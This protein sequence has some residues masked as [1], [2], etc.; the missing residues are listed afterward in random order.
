[1]IAS[2]AEVNCPLKVLFVVLSGH[3]EEIRKKERRN[4]SGT[5]H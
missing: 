2:A 1:M 4:Q 3:P 5:D